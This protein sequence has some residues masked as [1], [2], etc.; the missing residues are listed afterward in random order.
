MPGLAGPATTTVLPFS[1]SPT[2]DS[3]MSLTTIDNKMEAAHEKDSIVSDEAGSVL[4]LTPAEER[5][6]MRKAS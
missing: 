5:K 3:N 1:L 6:L 2:N 4:V